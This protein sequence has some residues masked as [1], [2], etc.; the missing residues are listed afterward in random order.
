MDPDLL[1]ANFSGVYFK[2]ENLGPYYLFQYAAK[3][4]GYKV[5]FN[6]T[7]KC[8][9]QEFSKIFSGDQPCQF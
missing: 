9:E 7:S 8:N 3:A 1:K 5:M 6:G 2:V 4:Y